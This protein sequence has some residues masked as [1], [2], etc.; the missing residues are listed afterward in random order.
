MRC[1]F[2]NFSPSLLAASEKFL[3][4]PSTKN[5]PNMP[6]AT[7]PLIA[8]PCFLAAAVTPSTSFC[9]F[10]SSSSYTPSFESFFSVSIPAVMASGLPERVPAWYIGP[11][12]ATISMISLRPPYAPTGRPPPMTLP[13]V[14]TSGVTPKYSCAPP[15]ETRNP[16]MTSSKTRRAPFSLAI[17]RSPSRNSWSGLMKPELPTTGSRMTAAISSLLSSK[18]AFTESRSLYVAQ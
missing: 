14:V 12:G 9:A 8:W 11:A 4:G 13:M 6:P 7:P 3:T 1:H 17:S 10:R 18:M 15:Y 16:V 5:Q 2:P